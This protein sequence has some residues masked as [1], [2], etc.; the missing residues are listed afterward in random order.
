MIVFVFF[1]SVFLEALN[2]RKNDQIHS[3][4]GDTQVAKTCK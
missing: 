2:K 4:E 1:L 3:D